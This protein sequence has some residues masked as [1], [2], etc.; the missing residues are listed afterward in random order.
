LV[1]RIVEPEPAFLDQDHGADRRDRLGRRR[2][3]EDCVSLHLHVAVEGHGADRLNVLPPALVYQR[4]Q[5]RRVASFH[6]TGQAGVHSRE[7][8]KGEAPAME[9][10]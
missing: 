2:E 1:H 3:P 10:G 4:Y 6:V 9:H 7:P 5:T 8:V